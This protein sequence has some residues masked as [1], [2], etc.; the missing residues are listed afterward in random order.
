MR[1]LCLLSFLS[2][3]SVD[4]FCVPRKAAVGNCPAIHTSTPSSTSSPTTLVN[5]PQQ[6]QGPSC[7]LSYSFPP[8]VVPE[9]VNEI[10]RTIFQYHGNVP[11]LH[12]FGINLVL[13]LTA[14]TKLLSALTPSGF[15]NAMGLGT[16]LWTTLGWRGWTYCV[17][18]LVLGQAV[19]KVQFAQKQ[20]AGLA[21]GR[22][23]RR[24]PENVWGSAA[25]GLACALVW[26]IRPG[27]DK[28]LLLL[29]YCASLAT[30]LADTFASE[31]GKAYGKT[32][33]LIT[34]FRR[35]TAGTEG[36][37]SVEGTVAAAVG[38]LLL[39]ACGKALGLLPSWST[40]GISAVA[41]FV[42]TNVESYLGATIQEG[43]YVTNEVIN[44]IN[45]LIGAGIAM[46]AGKYLLGM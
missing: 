35:T 37:V 14:R 15:V 38:G 45:T 40:V 33:F 36:A 18:Y 25:T 1:G 34:T 17:L 28:E 2:L 43:K 31:I 41:A 29:G 42:A 4:S 13:F 23:G 32:C 19:T 39:S 26:H 5:N 46:A 20:A 30:K 3:A 6:R 10:S 44:F 16:L 8:I 21:E 11:I 9:V 22:G 12:A 7:R 27:K 24:G